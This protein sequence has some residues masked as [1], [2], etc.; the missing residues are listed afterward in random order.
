MNYQKK[1]RDKPLNT[2]NKMANSENELI[3]W[4]PVDFFNNAF[5]SVIETQC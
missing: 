5:F 4:I 2:R 3:V 1:E